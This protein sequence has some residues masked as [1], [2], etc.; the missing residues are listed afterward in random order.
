MRGDSVT[1]E[2]LRALLTKE[3]FEKLKASAS[4]ESIEEVVAMTP[5]EAT[6]AILELQTMVRE[7]KE[8][9]D[10]V[11]EMQPAEPPQMTPAAYS[12]S[13]RA[14]NRKK[15]LWKRLFRRGEKSSFL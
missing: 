8:R 11:S 2:E 6:Q 13:R 9:L 12:R 1:A 5:A 14:R 10:R 4:L 7:L 15:S 3:E